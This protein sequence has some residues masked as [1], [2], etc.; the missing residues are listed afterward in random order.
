MLMCYMTDPSTGPFLQAAVSAL[1]AQDRISLK[2]HLG[3]SLSLV[4]TSAHAQPDSPPAHSSATDPPSPRSRA[5]KPHHAL[6]APWILPS[7]SVHWPTLRDIVW[8][9]LCALSAFPGI[10][11]DLLAEKLGHSLG[12]AHLVMLLQRLE[13]QGLVRCVA[14]PMH[15]DCIT[16]GT[17]PC[18]DDGESVEVKP[19]EGLLATARGLVPAIFGGGGG[20]EP[21]GADAEVLWLLPLVS[22]YFSEVG[23]SLDAEMEKY[24]EHAWV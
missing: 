7:G 10:P 11:E 3:S 15:V 24:G 13:A 16:G 8:Q 14:L 5:K 20:A 1:Q 22:H 17:A 6:A 4:S 21:R 23:A 2:P 18:A 19:A 9:V 12:R